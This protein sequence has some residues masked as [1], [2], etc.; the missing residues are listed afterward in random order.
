M[1]SETDKIKLEQFLTALGKSV[2]GPGQIFLT[3]GGTALLFGWRQMTVD[4]DLKAA[5]EPVGFFEAIA[6]LKDEL[7]VNVELASPDQFIPEV[8]G[9]RERSLFIARHG[10]VDFLHYDPV[11]QALAKIERGH[12]RDLVDVA[13]MLERKMVSP[14]QLWES[15]LLIEP[16]LLRFPAIDPSTFRSGVVAICRPSGET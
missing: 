1:R 5:P 10:E 11:S 4:I 12:A 9:W 16:E 8:P 2:R 13:A 15:Y 14:E 7:D 3:G 6:K